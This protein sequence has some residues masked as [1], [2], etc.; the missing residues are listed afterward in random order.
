[1]RLEL[2]M[3]A[4]PW[5]NSATTPSQPLIAGTSVKLSARGGNRATLK[6]V[7][8]LS[9]GHFVLGSDSK[10]VLATSLLGGGFEISHLDRV[11]VSSTTAPTG[12]VFVG[13]VVDVDQEVERSLPA[14]K[15]R[16]SIQCVDAGYF[17]ERNFVASFDM[18]AVN[19]TPN[20]KEVITHIL[21]NLLNANAVLATSVDT[22][23]IDIVLGELP[24]SLDDSWQNTT[25]KR[26][27]DDITKATGGYYRHSR[28]GV[29]EYHSQ[30]GA[31]L[32]PFELNLDTPVPTS[33][34]FLARP[35]RR[36]TSSARLATEVSVVGA[37]DSLLA[38]SSDTSTYGPVRR[39]EKDS[40]VT[41]AA[42][43]SNIADALLVIHKDPTESYEF[44][45]FN[46]VE[47]SRS[48]VTWVGDWLDAGQ[49]LPVTFLAFG[50]DA[51]ALFLEQVDISQLSD[52][53]TSF[54]IQTGQIDKLGPLLASI[55]NRSRRIEE[56]I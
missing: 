5:G 40:S 3:Q 24:L 35:T 54:K 2:T 30:S 41:S 53:V 25:V 1:M 7:A 50:L 23:E 10:G 18:T 6:F 15:C 14:G 43:A 19:P 34:D 45:F 33:G 29:F 32:A 26:L 8:D 49:R 37:G 12:T 9:R 46:G 39:V 55:M 13:Y 27:L 36:R 11:I 20:D 44:E 4:Y 21:Q 28:G 48:D 47:D 22:G 52:T 42:E 51:D 17:L 16:Y 38:T 31:D 56:G